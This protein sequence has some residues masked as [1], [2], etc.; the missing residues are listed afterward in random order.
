M[1]S[2]S[3]AVDTGVVTDEDRMRAEL[4]RL[5]ARFLS[6][7]PTSAD[8]AFA[9]GLEGGDTPLGRAVQTFARV[10]GAT[11][12]ASADDEYHDLFIGV[13]RGELLPYGSYYLTGFLHE[14]PLA[15]LRG[16]M[17]GLGIAA[18]P[19]ASEPEDHAA[20]V[21]EMMAGLIDGTFGEVR[22]LDKQK[23]FFDAHVG[24][25]MALFF[26]DLEG[27][28]ASVLYAALAQIGTRF[29]EIESAAFEMD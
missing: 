29:L 26:R 12:T 10:A 7:P 23:Q 28:S 14:K 24:S 5:L 25:W 16:D 15:R 3:T 11:D 9:A 21:L 19:D 17:A 20:A 8:L 18:D 2:D 22:P 27:A 13:G 4:Y 1:L 6:Q